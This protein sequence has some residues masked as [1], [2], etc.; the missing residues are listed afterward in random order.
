MTRVHVQSPDVFRY[1]LF[2]PPLTCSYVCISVD[3]FAL[4]QFKAMR[5]DNAFMVA[6]G[7]GGVLGFTAARALR[8]RGFFVSY[9]DA[10]GGGVRC[11]VCQRLIGGD[12]CRGT[13]SCRVIT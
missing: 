1:S 4:S 3:T 5:M 7:E 2:P 10:S 11:V 12:V 9:G 8:F 6:D 13:S